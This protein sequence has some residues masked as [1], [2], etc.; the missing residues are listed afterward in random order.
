MISVWFGSCLCPS[1]VLVDW[2]L[3]RA[4]KW[5]QERHRYR[6][7]QISIHIP[8]A[9]PSLPQS[10]TKCFRIPSA[11]R[12]GWSAGRTEIGANRRTNS[13]NSSKDECNEYGISCIAPQ[14]PTV[15][16]T[17]QEHTQKMDPV[18][19]FLNLVLLCRCVT[20]IT[21]NILYIHWFIRSF[22][23]PIQK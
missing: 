6:H 5:T 20:I 8:S 12:G 18:R 22:I 19:Q 1:K 13:H 10:G 23:A 3:A 7:N 4:S 15:N 9:L 16:H 2:R 17:S 14:Y 11:F 21:I